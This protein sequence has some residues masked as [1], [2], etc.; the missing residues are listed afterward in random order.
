MINSREIRA[1]I[2]STAPSLLKNLPASPPLEDSVDATRP[3]ALSPGARGIPGTTTLTRRLSGPLYKQ[4]G[5]EVTGEW[6][7]A[8]GYHY[9]VA[10]LHNLRTARGRRHPYTARAMVVTAVGF[11]FSPKCLLLSSQGCVGTVKLFL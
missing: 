5:I 9:P 3:V 7:V 10:E 2:K 4:R 11:L 6:F 8:G 1:K